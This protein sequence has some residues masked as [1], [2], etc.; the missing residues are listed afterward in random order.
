[1]E[2]TGRQIILA[3]ALCLVVG[4]VASGAG[5]VEWTTIG[6]G[7][8]VGSVAYPDGCAVDVTLDGRQVM[9][10]AVMDGH[11]E[12]VSYLLPCAGGVDLLTVRANGRTVHL[13]TEETTCG[14]DHWRYVIPDEMQ[15]LNGAG[16]QYFLPYVAG[17]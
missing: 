8:L 10:T 16:Y 7:A 1:M 9:F 13:I 3:L 15:G 6:R 17:N 14:V 4:Q 11:A 2:K 12:V 5:G